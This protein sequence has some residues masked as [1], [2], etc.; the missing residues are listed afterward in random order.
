LKLWKSAFFFSTTTRQNVLFEGE[1]HPDKNKSGGTKN[2]V[3]ILVKHTLSQ[4]SYTESVE[5]DGVS[6][7]LPDSN[8][9]VNET[10]LE[11]GCFEDHTSYNFQLEKQDGGGR[12]K[13]KGDGFFSSFL[14]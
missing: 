3:V 13:T 1:K 11:I 2:G 4:T 6:N 5:A 9:L 10:S 14:F 12:G 7:G 8:G